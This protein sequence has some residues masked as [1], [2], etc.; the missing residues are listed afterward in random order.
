MVCRPVES[1]AVVVGVSGAG[2]R[3]DRVRGTKFAA[4]FVSAAVGIN[5]APGRWSPRGRDVD[6]NALSTNQSSGMHTCILMVV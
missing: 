4:S 1:N 6:R 3:K 2:S 5:S